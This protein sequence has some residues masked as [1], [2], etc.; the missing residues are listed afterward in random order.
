MFNFQQSL[1][2]HRRG[3]FTV[4]FL[5]LVVWLVTR[6][7]PAHA[8]TLSVCPRGCSFTTITAAIAAANAGDTIAIGAGVYQEMLV[9]DK[10]L[11]LQGAGSAGTVVS[12]SADTVITVAQ[13][14]TVHLNNLTI[15]DAGVNGIVNHGQLTL[16]ASV[17]SRTHNGIYNAPTGILTATQ[18][19]IENSIWSTNNNGVTNFGRLSLIDSTV[20][21]G[22]YHYGAIANFGAAAVAL[23]LRSTIS[24]NSTTLG[25]IYNEQGHLQVINSTISSNNSS[26][27]LVIVNDNGHLGLFSSTVAYNTATGVL[28][29]KGNDAY[30][31]FTN[32][33]VAG[34]SACIYQGGLAISRGYNMVSDNTCGFNQIGDKVAGDPLLG[35]LQNNGGSTWT[36]TL[37]PASPALDA[38]GCFLPADQRGTAR[39][40]ST[41]CDIG[42]VEVEQVPV[43]QADNYT[44]FIDRP[45]VIDRDLGLLANDANASGQ[46]LT[47]LLTS[48]LALRG[49]ISLNAQGDFQFT[50][51]AGFSG[52]TAFTY[53]ISNGY[54][55]SNPVTVTITVV[56]PAVITLTLDA[57]PDS[58]NN[59]AF[60]SKWGTFYLDN[61]TVDDGDAY[62]NTRTFLAVPGSYTVGFNYTAGWFNTA[63]ACTPLS[64]AT[65]ALAQSSVTLN[66]AAGDT[67]TCLFTID[68]SAAIIARAFN[69]LVRTGANLGVPNAGDPWLEGWRMGVYLNPGTMIIG[70]VTAYAP[71]SD[72]WTRLYQVTFGNLRPGSY[73]VCTT[74]PSVAWLPTAPNT[75]DPAYGKPCKSVTL[76]PSQSATLLFGAYVPTVSASADVS[77]EQ[78]AIIAVDQISDLSPDDPI[79]DLAAIPT[80]EA[81]PTPETTPSPEQGN[82]AFLPLVNR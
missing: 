53:Q 28:G 6:T 71:S 17:V 32:N 77:P 49:L 62:T 68:R 38:G 81:T 13:D 42:A 39:P 40:E 20:R 67:V 22:R 60:S 64:N 31:V 59:L 72:A 57:R 7:Q 76:A 29:M 8:A 19:T 2:S 12:S 24:G 65:V 23:I 14:R 36:H 48:N 58:P 26:S 54:A 37:L 15:G 41:R 78:A 33:I 51:E 27:G 50:P 1:L 10:N 66:V 11:I 45:L 46:P 18:S 4:L 5:A 9:I 47:A 63:I 44:A 61:P 80:E 52:T 79:L 25:A 74:L 3:W 21:N 56:Q 82:R 43:A 34:P 73:T 75:I 16:Q 30:A 35:P 69:D 55:Q 70:S